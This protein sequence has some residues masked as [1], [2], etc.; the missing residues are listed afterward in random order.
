MRAMLK[1]AHRGFDAAAR[2]S[3]WAN[4]TTKYKL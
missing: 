2:E 1:G 4:R 3:S